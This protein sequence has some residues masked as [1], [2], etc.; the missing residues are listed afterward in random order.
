MALNSLR[1]GD[2]AKAEKLLDLM[3]GVYEDLQGLEHTSIIQ[4]SE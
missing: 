3:E 2:V 4:R 1:K